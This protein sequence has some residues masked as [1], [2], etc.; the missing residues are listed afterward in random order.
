MGVVAPNSRN[1]D[2]IPN[3]DSSDLDFDD[4]NLF[5]EKRFVGFD[6]FEPGSRLNYGLKWSMYGHKRDTFPL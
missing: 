2:K 1:S 3:E 5:A 4:T 6:M